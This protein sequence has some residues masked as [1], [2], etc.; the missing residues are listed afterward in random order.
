[1]PHSKLIDAVGVLVTY[2][3]ELNGIHC[4]IHLFNVFTGASIH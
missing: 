2:K 3:T 1:M 4:R